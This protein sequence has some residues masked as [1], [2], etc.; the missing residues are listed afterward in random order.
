MVAG[1]SRA[2]LGIFV[3]RLVQILIF[4]IFVNDHELTG[5]VYAQQGMFTLFSWVETF[6]I[7]PLPIK[8]RP[9]DLIF[10]IITF[11]AGAKGARV[12]PMRTAL[13][14]AMLTTLLFFVFGLVRGGDSRAAG[15]QVYLML[16]AP[17]AAFAIAATHTKASHFRALGKAMVYAA[18]YRA[19]MCLIFY[20]GY[21]RSAKEVP[22][23]M[24]THA[25]T[26]LWVGAFGLLTVNFLYNYRQSADKL[27]MFLGGPLVLAA[28]HFNN[29]RLAWVSLLLAMAGLF[30]L[31]PPS[32]LKRRLNRLA[33]MFLPV[34]VGYV[35]VGWGRTE[36]IFKPLASI[37]SV[38]SAPDPSTL[39]RNV[40]NL[41]LIATAGYN[42]PSHGTGWGH[43]YVELSNMYSIA[44]AMELW[45]YIPH[46]SILGLFAYTGYV[47]AFGFWMMFPTGIFFLL[48]S[49]RTSRDP[50]HQTIGLA[51]VLLTI[52]SCNQ[53]FG[54]MGIF[55]QTTM[56]TLSL[57][58]GAALRLPI[59][60]GAWGSG[61]AARPA[62]P[63]QPEPV[64]PPQV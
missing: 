56:Y 9:V 20:F 57:A 26:V 46:N 32:R 58:W 36:K 19:A 49:T 52:T 16:S 37:S 13:M 1:W 3:R 48:R 35:I 64:A 51:G 40:E 17:G 45:P 54:D 12:G 27:A 23:V 10:L 63:P 2:K 42:G 50:L 62:P 5:A 47:G 14:M 39:A 33:I 7:Q 22:P 31:M 18:F 43:K 44:D 59:E 6:L 53:M 15:W 30:F 21:A 29:R 8:I 34:M 41:S 24:T 61:A 4:L 38:S 55:S 28:I 60:A 25:D 11:T